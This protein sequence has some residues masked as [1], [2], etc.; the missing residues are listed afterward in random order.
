MSKG[1]AE[2]APFDILDNVR[3]IV[4]S[5]PIRLF[6]LLNYIYEQFQ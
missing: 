4:G 1:A 5:Q 2:T 3:I 6:I